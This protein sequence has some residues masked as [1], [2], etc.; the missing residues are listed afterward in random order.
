VPHLALVLGQKSK[1]NPSMRK[2]SEVRPITPPTV[3]L[4][5]GAA[6]S[7]SSSP[8]HTA[9]SEFH[10]RSVGAFAKVAVRGMRSH[11]PGAARGRSRGR[12]YSGGGEVRGAGRRLWI[13][14]A[15]KDSAVSGLHATRDVPL[16]RPASFPDVVEAEVA[17]V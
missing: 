13:V 14:A 1:L 3:P 2:A 10:S 17:G 6:S 12:G 15:P 5:C 7:S 11:L 8:H 4:T 16:V 9:V